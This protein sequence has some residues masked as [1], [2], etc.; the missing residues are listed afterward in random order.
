MTTEQSERLSRIEDNID[1]LKEDI[2]G[3]GNALTRTHGD[4]EKLDATLNGKIDRIEVQM[5]G[6]FEV[7]EQKFSGIEDKIDRIVLNTSKKQDNKTKLTIAIL[8]AVI[9]GV[10]G[11]L[12]RFI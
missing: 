9:G 2:A 8:A 10:I 6:K 3:F 4:L 11:A 12:S 7:V 1:N 5:S